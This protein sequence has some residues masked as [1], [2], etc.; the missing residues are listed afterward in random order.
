MIWPR[1]LTQ[2]DESYATTVENE[3]PFEARAG[4]T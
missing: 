1:A 4:R 3:W 2:I